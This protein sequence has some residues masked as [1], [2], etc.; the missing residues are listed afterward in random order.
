MI[1]VHEP[2]AFICASLKVAQSNWNTLEKKAFAIFQTFR[3][4]G[5]LFICDYTHIFTD[6]LKLLL[7]YSPTS[8]D[9]GLG[10]HFVSKVQMW[11]CSFPVFSIPSSM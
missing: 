7:V 1:K 8:L 9:V 5:Y 3:K 10:R 11:V 4:L 6:H 2:I